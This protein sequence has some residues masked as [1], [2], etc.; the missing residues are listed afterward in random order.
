MRALA[1]LCMV[2]SRRLFRQ[3]EFVVGGDAQ[4]IAL[5]GVKQDHFLCLANQFAH[6]DFAR[7]RFCPLDGDAAFFSSAILTPTPLLSTPLY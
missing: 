6:V 3:D 4:A 7:L 2:F 1:V 5:A